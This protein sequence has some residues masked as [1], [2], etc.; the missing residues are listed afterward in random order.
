MSE[1][2]SDIW[3]N[4]WYTLKYTTKNI[5]SLLQPDLFQNHFVVEMV[6][7]SCTP[8]PLDVLNGFGIIF[9]QNSQKPFPQFEIK[10][11]I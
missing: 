10:L 3:T 11:S 6:F 4:T 7:V 1:I 5:D 8:K 2:H 9:T